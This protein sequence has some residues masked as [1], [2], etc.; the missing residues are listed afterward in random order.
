MAVGQQDERVIDAQLR[1]PL[2]EGQ[3]EFVVEEPAEGTRAGAGRP[4]ELGQRGVVARLGVQDLRDGPEPVIAGLGQLQ[5]LLGRLAELVD[6]DPAQPG[7]G[8]S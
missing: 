7:A 3:A 4:A 8:P 6:E 5:R 1:A 2:I